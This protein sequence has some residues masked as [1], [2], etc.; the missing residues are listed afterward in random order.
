MKIMQAMARV[1]ALGAS[2]SFI[3]EKYMRGNEVHAG[4]VLKDSSL[5]GGVLV[6]HKMFT[7]AMAEFEGACGACGLPSGLAA[8]GNPLG[9]STVT[10]T[11]PLEELKAFA[12]KSNQIMDA[13]M[14][15]AFDKN[16]SALQVVATQISEILPNVDNFLTPKAF[17]PKVAKDILLPTGKRQKIGTLDERLD[18]KLEQLATDWLQVMGPQVSLVTRHPAVTQMQATGEASQKIVTLTAVVA[19]LE[20]K[21]SAAVQGELEFLKGLLSGY[22]QPLMTAIDD[23]LARC[24]ASGPPH[25]RQRKQ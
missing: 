18:T 23:H 5:D 19:Q 2:V 21:P 13:F 25:K 9:L 22:A 8:P 20:Q 6:F 11:L 7:T 12:T 3:R 17:H 16:V 10:M 24:K 14:A 4:S 15:T 1:H